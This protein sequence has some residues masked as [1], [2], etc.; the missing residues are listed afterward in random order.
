MLSYS[1]TIPCGGEYDVIICGGGF[2]GFAAAYAAAREGASVLLIE[3]TACLGGVGTSALV[4]HI[5]GVRRRTEDGRFSVCVQGIFA[6]LEKRLLARD[7]AVNVKSID[8]SLNPH[9]WKPSLSA[10]MIFDGEEMKLVLEEMLAEVGVTILYLTDVIDVQRVGARI[11]SV[12]IHNKNGLSY[13]KGNYFAD[14]TGDGDLSALAGA[15]YRMGDEEGGLSAASLEMH[16]ENVDSVTLSDY[17]RRTGDFRF[18]SLIE[19]A[20]S[21][22]DW[23]FDY[24]IF[25]S[26]QLCRKD[27][28]MINTIRQVGVNGIDANSLSQGI[29]SGRRESYRLLRIM[30]KYFPGFENATIRQ[31]APMIGIR[32][33]RRI[34]GEYTLTVKDLVEGVEFEDGIAL[35]GYGWDMPH[36]KHPSVQPFKGIQR[37]SYFT[38]IPY[39]CL[40]PMGLDN[41]LTVGRCISA[42]REV[43]GPVRVMGPCLA[44]G[45]AAGIALALATKNTVSSMRSIDVSVLRSKLVAYGGLVDRAQV[46][47]I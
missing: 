4:N 39:R 20:K 45:E 21:N 33:T 6:E 23:S 14:A 24:D 22:G 42:E 27:V 19:T 29:L 12:I 38:Q 36:P 7:A 3:R 18:R 8:T 17:M 43:L 34:I 35:S 37:R 25:I 28:F 31:V 9:G 10:G 15:D 47:Q 41:V 30:R 40:I 13:I 16:V 32:E 5:L 44:M 2:S 26:V 1:V 46:Y 11:Q